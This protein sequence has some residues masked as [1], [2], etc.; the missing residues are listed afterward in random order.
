M[1]ISTT[2]K[3]ALCA[4]LGTVF[5]YYFTIVFLINLPFWKFFAIE[6]IITLMHH[7]FNM[8]RRKLE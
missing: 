3:L 2:L 8:V 4:I 1:Y 7:L 5:T 6:V